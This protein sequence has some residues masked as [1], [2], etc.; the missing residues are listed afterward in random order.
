MEIIKAIKD[1]N[2]LRAL[3]ID[4]INTDFY[5]NHWQTVGYFVCALVKELLEGKGV[6]P[7][8]N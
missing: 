2:I 4:G 1:T 7:E 5:Q 6:P 8:I 3:G